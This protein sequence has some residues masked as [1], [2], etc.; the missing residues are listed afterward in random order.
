MPFRMYITV[1]RKGTPV[2]NVKMEKAMNGERS[3][4]IQKAGG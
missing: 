4:V 2:L 1:D 3:F